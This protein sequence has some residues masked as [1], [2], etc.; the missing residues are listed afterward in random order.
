MLT[1]DKKIKGWAV[2]CSKNYGL[3]AYT[4]KIKAREHAKF[5]NEEYSPKCCRHKVVSCEI[6]LTPISR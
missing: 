4:N 5:L 1:K 2:V 6:T 3:R